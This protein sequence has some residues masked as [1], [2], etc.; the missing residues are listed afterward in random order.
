M[1]KVMAAMAT[2]VVILRVTYRLPVS[3]DDR[4]NPFLALRR[5]Q[6]HSAPTNMSLSSDAITGFLWLKSF[7]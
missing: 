3:M 6:Y 1:A 7:Q 4:T 2:S 5:P